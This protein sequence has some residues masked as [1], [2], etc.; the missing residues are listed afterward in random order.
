MKAHN[1]I[2]AIDECHD[3]SGWLGYI[4][5]STVQN[6]HTRDCKRAIFP[7]PPPEIWLPEMVWNRRH[8]FESRWTTQHYYQ[9]EIPPSFF[10]RRQPTSCTAAGEREVASEKRNAVFHLGSCEK[11]VDNITY[12]KT[13]LI[14]P[15][16]F[17]DLP[18]VLQWI[19]GKP[20]FKGSRK[21]NV[22]PESPGSLIT[23][24]SCF[25]LYLDGY[26]GISGLP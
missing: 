11:L 22:L 18:Q 19:I 25:Q 3:K 16:R 26:K 20:S 17:L 12:S 5:T 13:A 6:C 8:C 1:F 24:S 9:D 14:V 7:L 2:G 15:V 4:G 10:L 21:Q 23:S